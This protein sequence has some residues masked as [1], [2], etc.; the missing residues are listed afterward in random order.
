MTHIDFHILKIV[1]H[2]ARVGRGDLIDTFFDANSETEGLHGIVKAIFKEEDT[3]A[4]ISGKT[5]RDVASIVIK[6]IQ[7]DQAKKKT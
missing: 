5:T 7:E 3:N 4:I 6:K 1:N 2:L